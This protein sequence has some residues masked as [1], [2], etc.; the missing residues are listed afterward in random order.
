[1]VQE[2]NFITDA[3]AKIL[4]QLGQSLSYENLTE[5][6][7]KMEP[8]NRKVTKMLHFSDN[9]SNLER[10]V[11]NH[12]QR[13][14]RELDKVLLKKFLRFL[15]F[16]DRPDVLLKERRRNL[17]SRKRGYYVKQTALQ[18]IQR[19]AGR[20]VDDAMLRH[21]EPED[22]QLPNQNNLKRTANRV[23]EELTPNEPNSFYF[24]LDTDYLQC[25]NFL[26]KDIRV[27]DQRHSVFSTPGQ[28]QLLKYAKKWFC[29][30]TFKVM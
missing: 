10:E 5:I 4:S 11:M 13:Y 15:E 12:L 2:C 19:P 20:I 23:R 24:K 9:L 21:I 6:Y 14:V 1:M 18:D 22:H 17:S 16:L 27:D 29:D 25:D 8:S 28:L 7:S 30:G 3:W 26:I